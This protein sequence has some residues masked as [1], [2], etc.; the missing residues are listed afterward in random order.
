MKRSVSSSPCLWQNFFILN[1]NGIALPT[2]Q[3]S[4]GPTWS[5][6]SGTGGGSFI[7]MG[8]C[9]L[10][11]GVSS[12]LPFSL[13]VSWSSRAADGHTRDRAGNR[14]EMLFHCQLVPRRVC[15]CFCLLP[16]KYYGYE[17]ATRAGTVSCEIRKHTA[18]IARPLEELSFFCPCEMGH[19][20]SCAAGW[21]CP[22]LLPGRLAPWQEFCCWHCWKLQLD[23]GKLM[24]LP[25]LL[26]SCSWSLILLNLPLLPAGE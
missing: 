7:T 6:F 18:G 1:G 5:W 13:S 16:M 10:H 25:L 26:L 14:W 2:S 17:C 15:I 23:W 4:T 24:S 21:I 9:K 19:R 22:P 3:Q 11:W 12:S 8:C 20:A